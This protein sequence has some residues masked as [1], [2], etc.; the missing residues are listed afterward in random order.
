MKMKTKPSAYRLLLAAVLALT[1]LTLQAGPSAAADPFVIPVIAS[2]TGSGAFATQEDVNAIKV[3]ES[4]VNA[5]GGI[6][7]RPISFQIE[8]DQTNPAVGV[9]LVN[10]LIAKKTQVF[11]GPTLTAVCSAI[12]PLLKDNGPMTYCYSPGLH[13]VQGS[14]MFSVGASTRDQALVTTRFLGDRHWNKIGLITSTD[15]SGQDFEAKLDAVLAEREN[16][17][18]TIA[19]REHFAVSDLSVAAQIARIKSS[20]AQVIIAWTVGSG[21]GTT[22]RAIKDAGVDL[23]VVGGLGNAVFAQLAQYAAIMP[24]ELYFSGMRGMIPLPFN[25]PQERARQADYFDG[26]AKAGLR[27]DGPATLAWDGTL[28]V[29]EALRA[30]GFDAGAQQ[31]RDYIRNQRG[32]VGIN[33]TY[34]FHDPEQRGIGP[35]AIVVYRFDSQP[36]A[37]VPISKPGGAM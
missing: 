25:P 32:W 27:P 4:V 34:D 24:K 18:L 36:A 12:L 31:I 8:D 5:H 21:F 33:G 17:N 20:G 15:A 16:Q 2:V 30:N 14:Y 3:I 6:R 37:F 28:L 11:L 13:P 22:L 10:E 9:Q 35:D 26:F 23:P 19:D 1:L 29:L 7:G